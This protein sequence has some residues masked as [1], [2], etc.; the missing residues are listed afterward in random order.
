MGTKNKPGTFDCYHNA[1]PNE[2][3]F[4]LLGRD[5]FAPELVEIW[6][7]QRLADIAAGERPESDRTMAQEAYDCAQE[8][9]RWRAANMGAW[10]KSKP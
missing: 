10:R 3:M 6:G 4:V 7:K 1:L 2:P 5:P 8:M 9:M